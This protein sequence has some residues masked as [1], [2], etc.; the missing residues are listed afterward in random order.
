MYILLR[1]QV[2][3]YILYDK[4]VE[5]DDEKPSQPVITGKPTSENIRAQ[6]GT[7]VTKLGEP[8]I[9]RVGLSN[10]YYSKYKRRY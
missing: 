7:Y 4:K 1:G 6:L 2:T 3:I 9:N 10:N 5:G 8:R